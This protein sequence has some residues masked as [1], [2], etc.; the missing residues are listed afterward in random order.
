MLNLPKFSDVQEASKILKGHAVRTPLLKS[1]VLNEQLGARVFFKPECLQRTGSFKFRGAY[2]AMQ[3][4]PETSRGSGVLA[5][6]SGNHAQGIAEAA[7]LM[8]YKATIIMPSDAPAT[9]V[10]RTRRLGATIIFYDR[11]NEDREQLLREKAEETGMHVIHPFDN[12]HVIAGQ[13]TSGLE[14]CEDLKAMDIQPD[15]VLVNAGG[16]GLLAGTYLSFD[17]FFKGTKVHTVEPEGHDDQARSHTKGERVGGNVQEAS[18]CDA[19]VTPMPGE[20]SFAMLNGKLARGLTVSDDDAL[21]AVAFAF[22]EMKLVVEPGGAVSLAALLSGKL[23]VSGKI[24]V[25]V[26][27]GGNIDEDM[28]ARALALA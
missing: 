19:I 14:V 8:G 27:T 3:H 9:K 13:G 4:V 11:Q 18:V 17:H 6:S 21:R 23:D 12:F 1:D 10:E 28:L 20:L 2:N 25:A 16:G 24:V 15:H 26:L 22:R 7:G 5:C